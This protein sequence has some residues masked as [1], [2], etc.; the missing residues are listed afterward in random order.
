MGKNRRLM[1]EKIIVGFR[2][3]ARPEEEPE[4]SHRGQT[5]KIVTSEIGS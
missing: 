2:L 5:L 3:G 4:L 1:M